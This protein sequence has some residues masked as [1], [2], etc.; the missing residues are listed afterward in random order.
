MQTSQPSLYGYK[1]QQA[2]AGY[3]RK[4]P[5]CVECAKFGRVTQATVVDHIQPH[6]GNM[7]MFWDRDNWQGLCKHCHDSHKQRLEKSGKVMGCDDDGNPIDA[8][9]HWNR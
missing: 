9:H 1:W 5:L 4:H 7:K 6:R 8:N 2:R 3:L